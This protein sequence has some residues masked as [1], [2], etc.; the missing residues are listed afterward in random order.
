MSAEGA[1]RLRRRAGAQ[2][3]SAAWDAALLLVIRHR[4]ISKA[5]EMALNGTIVR[6]YYHGEVVAEERVHSEKLLLW[7]LEKGAKLL[8]SAEAAKIG[9]DWDGAM[10]RLEA[11]LLGHGCRVWK[12]RNGAWRTNFPPPP[13]YGYGEDGTP[14]APDYERFLSDEEE[15]AL[16]AA[17]PRHGQAAMARD[18]FFGFTPRARGKGRRRQ[19]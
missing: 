7:L 17:P 1:H 15:A 14:G 11:G 5:V 16:E 8:D 13:G 18:V 10:G 9:A 6:R 2:G 19:R 12:D 4:A 3:F